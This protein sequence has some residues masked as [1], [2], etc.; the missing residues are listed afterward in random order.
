[1]LGAK[2]GYNTP[3]VSK[4]DI[5]LTSKFST[6]N[7]AGSW[8]I[9]GYVK[10]TTG[11]VK[12]EWGDSTST[13]YG[14]GNSASQFTFSKTYTS[15]SS[16]RTAT[17]YSTDSTGNTKLGAVTY[18]YPFSAYYRSVDASYQ[19]SLTFVYIYSNGVTSVNLENC[20]A[21]INLTVSRDYNAS[22]L[23]SLNL[24]GISNTLKTLNLTSCGL[25]TLDLSNFSKLT[26]LIVPYN[27]LGTL[28]VS[29]ME[30]LESLTC[31]G[32]SLTSINIPSNL[33]N[34]WISSNNS[35]G[36]LDLSNKSQ[37]TYVD[38]QACGL[39][40]LN[41]IGTAVNQLSAG[42]NS[43]T[44]ITG[45][46]TTISQLAINGNQ[47]TSLNI[48]SLY[49]SL[50]YLSVYNNPS[51]TSITI[52]SGVPIYDLSVAE[53]SISSLNLDN[54]ASTLS[55]LD[56]PLNGLT[57]ISINGFTGSNGKGTLYLYDNDLS[58]STID[59]FFTSLG[60]A[61]GFSNYIDISNNPG[62]CTANT[63]IAT[64]KGWS[65]YTGC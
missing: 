19:T 46:P 41:L 9:S 32:C 15:T 56:V 37:L 4:T 26:S 24:K 28:D 62:S 1:M 12:L 47:F 21:L 53:C 22:V 18:L 55:Y 58:Q 39:T 59:S 63:S 61:A 44:S 16:S 25:T 30:L 7:T 2:F 20:I 35:L 17:L 48:S 52:A 40:S 45:V 5:T 33:K 23:S 34:L 43:L 60:T 50:V 64:N 11:Y 6:S 3:R 8:S 14:N 65:V 10:S 42:S 13:V 29:H 54:I 51:L 36:T 27:P 38:C 49:T 31:Y 57:S